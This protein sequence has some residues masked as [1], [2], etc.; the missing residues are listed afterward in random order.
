MLSP[1][2][3]KTLGKA[4][5]K[6]VSLAGLVGVCSAHMQ[7][8]IDLEEERKAIRTVLAEE[9]QHNSCMRHDECK[10]DLQMGRL[11]YE[12]RQKKEG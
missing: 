6:G 4:L 8:A 12:S 11:C 2:A 1:E 5:P 10:T 3:R 9:Q 7:K